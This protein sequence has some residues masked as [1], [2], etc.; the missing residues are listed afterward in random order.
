MPAVTLHPTLCAICHTEGNA[1]ELYPA[2]F[3]HLSFSAATFSARRIPD[4]V[5]YRI[6]KCNTCGLVRSDPVADSKSLEELYTKSSFDYKYE[7]DNIR[8][9][10]RRYLAKTVRYHVQKGALLEIG[11][12]NG[13]FL[14]EALAQGYGPVQGIET[15][16]AAIENAPS[17]IRHSIVCDTMRPGIFLSEQFEIICMFQVIDHI[18]DPVILL[19]ECLRILKPGGLILS[20]NHNVEALSSRVM[21]K[22]SPIMDIEHTFLYSPSTIVHLLDA[23]GFDIMHVGSAWN[24]YSLYYLTRLV[25]WSNKLRSQLIGLVDNR[26]FRRLSFSVPLGNLY[27]IGRKS[28]YDTRSGRNEVNK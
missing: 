12:G 21:K 1:T 2:T 23:R 4:G 24:R 18:P 10:Y 28:V 16:H 5:H 13:F 25:P 9:T 26:F 14:E 19:D 20:L 6:V 8:A 11:C 17:H 22:N 27:V 3:D 7:V 15:S